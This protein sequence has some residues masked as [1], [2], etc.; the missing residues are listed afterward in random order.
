MLHSL[1]EDVAQTRER[2][3]PHQ[4]YITESIAM[5]SASDESSAFFKH[6]QDCTPAFDVFFRQLF[7][8]EL[9]QRLRSVFFGKL[10]STLLVLAKDDR[11]VA[12]LR[13]LSE[14]VPN[15][16]RFLEC[17]IKSSPDHI[18]EAHENSKKNESPAITREAYV[19]SGHDTGAAWLLVSI[20]VQS[21]MRIY[22]E[23]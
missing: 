9:L 17:V 18:R 10:C 11:F 3:S 14:S 12:F 2:I 19:S 23:V 1:F 5:K 8:I 15:D 21:E 4:I 13:E 7:A 22:G 6:V 16:V 20:C